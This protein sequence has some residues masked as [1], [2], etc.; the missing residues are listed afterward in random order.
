L[1]TP[2]FVASA[3]LSIIS[4][5][6]DSLP[7]AASGATARTA[8]FASESTRSYILSSI[9][10]SNESR[11]VSTNPTILPLITLPSLRIG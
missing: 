10:L 11:L 3:V 7:L 1:V 2:V 4:A 8:L 9:K 6:N 5:I